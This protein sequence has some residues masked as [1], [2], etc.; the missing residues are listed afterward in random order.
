MIYF[1]N[2]ITVW[3]WPAPNIPVVYVYK[4]EKRVEMSLIGWF[5]KG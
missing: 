5:V 2:L 3:V 4:V 1:E